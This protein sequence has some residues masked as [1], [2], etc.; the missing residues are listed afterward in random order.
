MGAAAYSQRYEATT[1]ARPDRLGNRPRL[2][3]HVRTRGDPLGAPLA[4]YGE[5]NGDES[6]ATIQHAPDIGVTFLDTSDM[7]GSGHN[8]QLVG[9]AIA[10]RRE[11]AQ[12]ATKFGIVRDG[13]ERRIDNRPE[14]VE[15]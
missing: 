14:S 7:Y 12:I 1:S 15:L 13:G 9:R 2:H 6:V 10:G 4:A 5:S 3:G 8:E 11:E